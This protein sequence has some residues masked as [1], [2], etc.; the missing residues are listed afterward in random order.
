MVEYRRITVPELVHMSS[1]AGGYVENVK[2]RNFAR[3][4]LMA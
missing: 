3:G 4:H 1:P 2:A